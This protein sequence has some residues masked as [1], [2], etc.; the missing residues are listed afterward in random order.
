LWR[1]VALTP[2]LSRR[3]REFLCL[4]SRRRGSF[5]VSSPGGEEVS[6]SP[7]PEEREFLCLLSRREREFLCLLS[8]RWESPVSPLPEEEEVHVLLS[9]K[10]KALVVPSPPGERARVRAAAGGYCVSI[11]NL[12]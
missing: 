10:G 12:P 7:L 3:E 9:P 8:R 1:L 11:T 5:C 2:A 6:V 4:L